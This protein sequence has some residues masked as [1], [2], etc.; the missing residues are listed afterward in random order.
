MS[1]SPHTEEL[2]REYRQ[3]VLQGDEAGALAAIRRILQAD[4][5]DKT[6]ARDLQRRLRNHLSRETPVIN[7]LMQRGD[8]SAL[9]TNLARLLELATEKELHAALPEYADWQ[10]AL[11]R[12]QHECDEA[13]LAELIGCIGSTATEEQEADLLRNIETLTSAKRLNLTAP[14]QQSLA[15]LKTTIRQAQEKR[16][17]EQY[18]ATEIER[19]GSMLENMEASGDGELEEKKASFLHA[20]IDKLR[21]QL[22]LLRRADIGIP[23]DMG[24]RAEAAISRWNRA[25][26]TVSRK[27]RL[28]LRFTLSLAGGFLLCGG[29]YY[30]LDSKASNIAGRLKD[31]MEHQQLSEAE[32][33]AGTVHENSI[34]PSFGGLGNQL[35]NLQRWSSN[36]RLLARSI[37]NALNQLDANPDIFALWDPSERLAFGDS[38]NRLPLEYRTRRMEQWANITR[39]YEQM[40]TNRRNHILSQISADSIPMPELTGNFDTDA[41]KLSEQQQKLE[42]NKQLFTANQRELGLSIDILQ[43][44]NDRLSDINS[45]LH[46]I[47]QAR[48]VEAQLREARTLETFKAYLQLLSPAKYQPVQNALAMSGKLPDYD[49]IVALVQFSGDN[50]YA[51]RIER[52]KQIHLNGQPTFTPEQPITQQQLEIIAELFRNQ[53]FKKPYY[54]IRTQSGQYYLAEMRPSARDG[55]YIVERSPIDPRFSALSN[56]TATIPANQIA[57]IDTIDLTD[58]FQAAGL[59]EPDFAYG[60]ANLLRILGRIIDY[61]RPECPALAKAY[62][63]GKI[64]DFIE[65]YPHPEIPGA[66]F[67]DTFERDKASFHHHLR[68]NVVELNA[69]CWLATNPT[70]LK[71]EQQWADWF[72]RHKNPPYEQEVKNRLTAH[73]KRKP[74]YVGFIDHTGAP[75]FLHALPP[76]KPIWYISKNDYSLQLMNNEKSFENAAYLSPLISFL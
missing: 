38:I 44:I 1:D 74:S 15:A 37:D 36:I 25:K 43:P 57:S 50:T 7:D 59:K 54:R 70:T 27:R 64:L 72:K 14:Q 31:L 68:D 16:D 28:A 2:Y 34:L 58:F 75:V 18:A 9:Q 66:C 55:E 48:S 69:A 73:D 29:I 3:K 53:N 24:E 45:I 20:R 19:L 41:Q 51:E 26:A 23:E 42:Q 35:D 63:Y 32:S 21:K 65:A 39:T 76:D 56:N 30:Y 67:S 52:S 71:E 61:D 17:R 5:H 22:T 4:P 46:S 11:A 12:W 33:L 8:M 13:E 40:L 47:E 10:K 49:K 62:F 6:A 60:K